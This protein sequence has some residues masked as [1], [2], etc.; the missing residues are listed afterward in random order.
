MLGGRPPFTGDLTQLIMQKVMD[1]PPPLSTLRSDIQPEVERVV[2]RALEKDPDKRPA[3]VADWLDEF[4]AAVGERSEEEDDAESRVVILAPTGAEVYID[5]ERHGSIGSSGRII[6][7]SVAPGRHKLRVARAGERDDERVIEVR[8]GASEQIIQAQL[9][10]VAGSGN[11][12]SPSRGGSIGIGSGSGPAASLPG[13]V[14]CAQCGSRFAAGVRFCGRCGG[15]VF[16]QVSAGQSA[17]NQGASVIAHSSGASQV[18]GSSVCPR[19]G[20]DYPAGT[21]FC[22]RCGL[23]IGTGA[24][25]SRPAPSAGVMCSSCSTNY[26]AGTKFCG[27]CGTV[28]KS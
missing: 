11:A 22:G 24:S 12:V 10:P 3:S 28:I 23:S 21:K 18:S 26:P 20:V 4:E 25:G 15:T 16:H 6:L 27:R 17:A 5:D 9:R 14:V 7:S 8:P 1:Q 13:V 19:C 2:M